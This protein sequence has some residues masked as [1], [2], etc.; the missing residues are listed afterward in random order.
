MAEAHHQPA[1]CH[2]VLVF[3][4]ICCQQLT[5]EACDELFIDVLHDKAIHHSSGKY[6]WSR[7]TAP[8]LSGYIQTVLQF[9]DLRSTLKQCQ[10]LALVVNIFAPPP[11][12]GMDLEQMHF[13]K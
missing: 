8:D 10:P 6:K 7:P 9:Q 4:I 11:I 13:P 1:Q 3:A 5:T 12:K 2:I